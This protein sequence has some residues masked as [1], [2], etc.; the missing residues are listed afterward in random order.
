MK[1]YGGVDVE[2]QNFLTSALFRGELS[3]SCLTRFTP[4]EGARGIHWAGH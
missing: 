2:K 3:A 4:V 1:I